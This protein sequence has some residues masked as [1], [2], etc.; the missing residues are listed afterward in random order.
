VLLRLGGL[1]AHAECAEALCRRA[2][3]A[4]DGTLNPKA[5]PRIDT[6]G[7]AVLARVFAREA[8]LHVATS[9]LQLV[10]G[11]GGADDDRL[12]ELEAALRTHDIAAAQAGAMAD[13]D[14]AADVLYGRSGGT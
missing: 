2:A 7:L 14:A 10:R 13:M 12:A 4:A 5:D 1:I 9:G 8:A 11:A 3:R 6:A